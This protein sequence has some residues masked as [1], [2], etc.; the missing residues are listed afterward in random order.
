M[1]LHIEDVEVECFDLQY[2]AQL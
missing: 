2:T 1:T